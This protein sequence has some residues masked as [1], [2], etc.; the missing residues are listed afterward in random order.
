MT[1]IVIY[2]NSHAATLDKLSNPVT[3]FDREAFHPKHLLE[4][5]PLDFVIGLLEVNFEEYSIKFF[6]V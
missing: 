2:F 5:R 1:Y 6:R 3:P 4:E